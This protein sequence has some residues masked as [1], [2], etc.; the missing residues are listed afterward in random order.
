MKQ[1]PF[2]PWQEVQERG[3]THSKDER[4]IILGPHFTQGFIATPHD[5]VQ[6]MN[7]EEKLEY[8]FTNTIH[9]YSNSNIQ[10]YLERQTKVLH[11]SFPTIGALANV[12]HE[13]QSGRSIW[14][15]TWL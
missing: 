2:L 13:V 11:G 8:S 12:A 7:K 3:W 4:R 5:G 1:Q 6:L 9:E 14:H 10:L 15:R